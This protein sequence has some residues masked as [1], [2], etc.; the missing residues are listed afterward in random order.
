MGRNLNRVCARHQGECQG[1]PRGA[2]A[3]RQAVELKG[4]PVDVRAIHLSTDGRKLNLEVPE[5]RPV[6]QLM[7]KASLKTASGAD[8]PVE[9]YGTINAVPHL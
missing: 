6:M 4:E 5:I 9:Y 8:L 7:L 1:R 2:G 3:G